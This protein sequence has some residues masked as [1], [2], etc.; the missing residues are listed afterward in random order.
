MFRLFALLLT[1]LGL[2]A[3]Q[4]Q[5][6]PQAAVTNDQINVLV[7]NASYAAAFGH[8]P[9]AAADEDTRIRTH[10]AYAE[11]VLR[12]HSVE[13][14]AAA[15]VQRRTQTLDLLHRYWTAGVFPRNY[16]HP[17]GRKPCFIDRDGRLCAVGY[18]VA[19]TAGRPLAERI[20][21][22][23]QYDYIAD[24]R[25]PELQEWV[26]SSGL[27]TAECALIQPTYGVLPA[28]REEVPVETSYAI[29]SAMWSGLN[30]AFGAVNALQLG[31]AAPRKEAGWIGLVSGTGQL[32]LG[33]LNLPADTKSEFISW[34]PLPTKSYAAE[35]TVS[36]VNMGV[37]TATLALSAW[38]LLNHRTVG[39]VP[40]TTV[41]VVNYP[42]GPDPT[43]AGLA[44]TRR[45]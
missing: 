1:M 22:A 40:R 28:N 4:Q 14:M 44:L 8:E 10:L 33:A 34:N 38:N 24:M 30:V 31:Q 15:Q 5:P 43:G 18:L 20:N 7:G 35:R 19:E 27:T 6:A 45:F 21:A 26:A 41:G 16:D 36:F 42:A 13:G 25:L 17:E 12:A 39:S 37:G 3:Y 29:P 11:S 9:E 2:V 23:H 32:L